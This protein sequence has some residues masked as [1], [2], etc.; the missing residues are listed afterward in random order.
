MVRVKGPLAV[1]PEPLKLH[2]VPSSEHPQDLLKEGKLQTDR[3]H[4]SS[5]LT[6]GEQE[7]AVDFFFFEATPAVS[8][9]RSL[10]LAAASACA[11]V[12]PG[13]YGGAVVAGRV[14]AATASGGRKQ[15]GA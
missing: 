14:E 5:L 6:G 1:D 7:V 4:F 9:R 13:A 2:T 11:A 3:A 8:S 12:D 10:A 15:D